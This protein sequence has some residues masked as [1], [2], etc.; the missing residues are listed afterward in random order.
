MVLAVGHRLED[1]NSFC[2]FY[3]LQNTQKCQNKFFSFHA[4]LYARVR[5]ALQSHT[6]SYESLPLPVPC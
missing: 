1:P 5:S 3:R 2:E 4:R 6:L